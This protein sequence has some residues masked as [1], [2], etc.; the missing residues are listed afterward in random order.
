MS[1]DPGT[2]YSE[3]FIIRPTSPHSITAGDGWT[4]TQHNHA[5]L[6]GID[7]ICNKSDDCAPRGSFQKCEMND[8]ARGTVTRSYRAGR[9]QHGA[10][11]GEGH[12]PRARH[13]R[14][15]LDALRLRGTIGDASF[16]RGFVLWLVSVSGR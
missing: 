12:R 4:F 3:Q 8:S 1:I 15:P 9:E 7:T 10:T 14:S 16:A 5:L 6:F 13:R 2:G 11:G